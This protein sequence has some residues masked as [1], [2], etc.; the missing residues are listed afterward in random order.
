MDRLA[1]LKASRMK[2]L[3]FKKRSELEEICR[4]TH[5]EPD[6]STVAEK[7]SALIDSGMFLCIN[8]LFTYNLLV[9]YVSERL[10]S[11]TY[12]CFSTLLRS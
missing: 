2:E 6:P 12:F 9:A 3:V 4:L 7:A 5:I 10:S 1:K 11:A 8:R